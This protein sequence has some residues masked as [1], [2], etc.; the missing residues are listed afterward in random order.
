MN[1]DRSHVSGPQSTDPGQPSDC[2][3]GLGETFRLI[4]AAKASL[5]TLGEHRLAREIEDACARWDA[6]EETQRVIA[7]REGQRS[8]EALYG[9]DSE[10]AEVIGDGGYGI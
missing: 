3:A 6:A 9:Q 10:D 8:G 2:R 1:G 7:A 4:R 5:E